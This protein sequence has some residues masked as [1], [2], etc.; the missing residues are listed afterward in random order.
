MGDAVKLYPATGYVLAPPDLF[1][2]P[3]VRVVFARYAAPPM[4]Y[5]NDNMVLM[6][7]VDA[8]SGA[9]ASPP[10]DIRVE[11]A[12][13]GQTWTEV[14]RWTESDKSEY[15]IVLGRS[16]RVLSSDLTPLFELQ[17]PLPNHEILRV[18][19]RHVRSYCPRMRRM[20][21]GEE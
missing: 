7:F 5:N 16:Y 15:M 11:V 1:V 12:S 10:P 19:A 2:S 6:G 14:R 3:E 13:H 4:A 20:L 18:G 8:E 17:P 21:L 9:P